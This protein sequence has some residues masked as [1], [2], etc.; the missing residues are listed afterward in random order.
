[1]TLNRGLTKSLT[2]LLIL[3]LS[4]GIKCRA[5]N[6]NYVNLISCSIT[7]IL[8]N[9]FKSSNSFAL[10]PSYISSTN[11]FIKACLLNSSH[12]AFNASQGLPC[13]QHSKYI[14]PFPSYIS[15][16]NHF[17]KACFFISSHVAFNASR[18]LPC[19]QHS[20]YIN[21]TSHNLNSTNYTIL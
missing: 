19:S 10:F 5:Y 8:G 14:F 6:D 9:H 4:I 1:M 7:N 12:V 16:T 20:K 11:H 17:I 21:A 2:N 13:S 3:I 18:G 15:S